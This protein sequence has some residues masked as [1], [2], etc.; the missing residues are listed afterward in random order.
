MLANE[1]TQIIVV[2]ANDAQEFQKQF[3]QAMAMLADKSPTYEFNHAMGF[4]AYIT[5]TE[6]TKQANRAAD[7][8]HSDGMRFKCRNC[9]LHELETDGR[10]KKVAC[11][12]SDSGYCHLERE[13][14]DVFY[15]R[16]IMKELEPIGEPE[17]LPEKSWRK[18]NYSLIRDYKR[19]V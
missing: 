17:K 2:H 15:R 5:Y 16:Y 18:E 19:T 11:K 13:A 3:N 12:F 9:P 7:E 10:K 4:C 14:C 6:I 1:I 8:V